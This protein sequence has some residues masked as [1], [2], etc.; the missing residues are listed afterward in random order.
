MEKGS[1]LVV[2]KKEFLASFK[3]PLFD[4]AENP[5]FIASNLLFFTKIHYSKK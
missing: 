3:T 2:G 1:N 5:V 4:K